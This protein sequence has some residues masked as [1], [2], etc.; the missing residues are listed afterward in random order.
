M[1]SYRNQIFSTIFFT[2]F[3]II[4]KKSYKHFVLLRSLTLL[5]NVTLGCFFIHDDHDNHR[6]RA[7]GRTAIPAFHHR[8]RLPRVLL[9]TGVYLRSCLRIRSPSIRKPSLFVSFNL[10]QRAA[11]CNSFRT[12]S[13]LT[14]L[15]KC[16]S[17]RSKIWSGMNLFGF[18]PPYLVSNIHC[19]IQASVLPLFF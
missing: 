13:F 14:C 16:D 10:I 1:I 6:F 18:C 5:F 11:T 7:I 12:S 19:R 17:A 4:G 15:S 9:P 8:V 3:Q 2:G